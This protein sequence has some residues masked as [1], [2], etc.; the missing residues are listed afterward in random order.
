[1]FCWLAWKQWLSV[2]Y[3]NEKDQTFYLLLNDNPRY[4]FDQHA[5]SAETLHDALYFEHK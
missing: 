1:M 2:Q 4:V 3:L 5:L